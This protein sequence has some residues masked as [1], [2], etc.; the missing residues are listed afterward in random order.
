VGLTA[1]VMGLI[2]SLYLFVQAKSA[3]NRAVVAEQKEKQL[4][5]QAERNAG[6]SKVVAKGGL[7][8]MAGKYDE[9]EQLIRTVPPH[10]SMVA[11]YNV[12]GGIHARHGQWL[13]ALTNWNLVVQYAPDDHIGYMHLAP[14]LLQLDDVN[15]YKHCR[16]QILQHF[17]D[18]SDPRIAERMVKASL[19]LPPAADELATI[20]KMAGVAGKGE[21][22]NENWGYNLFAK[23]FTEYR[24][25]HYAGAVEVL[26]QVPP[27]DCGPYCR[28]EA[29]LVLA[30]AQFQLGQAQASRESFA[31]AMDEAKRRLPREG[32]LG[33]EWNDW[34]N[35][36]LLTREGVALMPDAGKLTV[37]KTPAWQEAL[38]KAGFKFTVEQQDDGTWEVGLDDQPVTDI[39]MLHDAPLSRLT[40]M[41]TTVADL[42][43][44]RGLRL[45][46][47]RLAGTKVTD[48]S[49]LKDMP[50]E[51][52]QISGTPVTDLS[53][54]RGMP[55]KMLNMTG[56][57]GITTLEPLK[58]TVTFQSVILPPNA[59]DFGFLRN[60]PNLV[61]LS[62]K[63][64]SATKGPAQTAA[65]FWAQRDAKGM[66]PAAQP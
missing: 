24:L 1:L 28:T 32:D 52:L 46:W 55:L 58:E 37:P 15:G 56:C 17:G 42:T 2:L 44:L 19:I 39:S 11:L 16:T 38:T 30:M 8:L 36:R 66:T 62:F 45:K 13:E 12:F 34:I 65:E 53:P 5:E 25:G 14:L 51:S 50:L 22:N 6:D 47:L 27:M 54:L 48:L 57:T 60:E 4:R 18:T 7:L 23:G 61:R 20:T 64:D 63:Y 33:E 26:Q 3:L 59:K 31:K 9:S 41:H 43:P 29:Y 49:P 40:L 21:V 10:A 35:V